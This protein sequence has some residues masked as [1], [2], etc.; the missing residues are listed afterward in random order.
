MHGAWVFDLLLLVLTGGITVLA[1][2]QIVLEQ[3]EDDAPLPRTSPPPATLSRP[4]L[5]RPEGPV[6]GGL[7]SE[8][9]R[10]PVATSK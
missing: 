7:A 2:R 1:F 5:R 8:V 3:Q 4:S 9:R 10:P 6:V